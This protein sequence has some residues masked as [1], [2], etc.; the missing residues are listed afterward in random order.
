MYLSTL[1]SYVR[2]IGGELELVVKLPARASIRLQSL[3]DI[4][5]P[6]GRPPTRSRAKA[7]AR[8]KPTFK[9]G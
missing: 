3:G 9:A 4:A 2:A 5:T 7:G 8:A 1:R 6:Q